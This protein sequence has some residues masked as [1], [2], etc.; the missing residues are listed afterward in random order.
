MAAFHARDFENA[1]VVGGKT[2]LQARAFLIFLG[3]AE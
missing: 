3:Y 2:L 1:T